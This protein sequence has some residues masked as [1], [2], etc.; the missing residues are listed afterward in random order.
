MTFRRGEVV[1]DVQ[2]ENL[3]TGLARGGHP[4]KIPLTADGEVRQRAGLLM[5]SIVM[6]DNLATVLDSEIDRVIG[7]VGDMT[8]VDQALRSTLGRLLILAGNQ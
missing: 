7:A 8:P 6:T 3:G 1:L 2:A 4:S 5:D